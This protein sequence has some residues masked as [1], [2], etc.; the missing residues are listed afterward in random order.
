LIEADAPRELPD[1]PTI[2]MNQPELDRLFSTFR[3]KTFT[4]ADFKRHVQRSAPKLWE[5]I[6]R[7]RG[8]GGKGKGTPTSNHF[9]GQWLS[10]K[11]RSGKLTSGEL[12]SSEPG[13]GS[14]QTRIWLRPD[15]PAG[16]TDEA[17][18]VRDQE[19]TKE[20][21]A[22]QLPISDL[23][24]EAMNAGVQRPAQRLV[25]ATHYFRNPYVSAAAKCLAKGICDFCHKPAP[26]SS[27]A[28]PYLESHHIV[29][30]AESG[31]D[32]LSNA[33]ALCPN[34]HRRMHILSSPEDREML[35]ARVAKRDREL[36]RLK[37]EA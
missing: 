4:T 2:S 1:M 31:P 9:L 35:Q 29:P 20:S 32:I 8:P 13:W 37:I 22:L 12:I 6:E 17:L 7:A 33:V 10:Y 25:E 23:I 27:S 24:K 36:K 5:D 30:L 16:G 21:E 34:C 15:T 28:G 19:A 26:F 11:A 3:H 18:K 14:P